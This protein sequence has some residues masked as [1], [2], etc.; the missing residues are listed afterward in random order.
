MLISDKKPNKRSKTEAAATGGGSGEGNKREKAKRW[1]LLPDRIAVPQ[2]YKA[3][4]DWHDR[5]LTEDSALHPFS[6][7]ARIHV[8]RV[9]VRDLLQGR[10]RRVLLPFLENLGSEAHSLPLLR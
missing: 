3:M 4:R 6:T 1:T 2:A 8:V 9:Y 7:P 5:L 10:W